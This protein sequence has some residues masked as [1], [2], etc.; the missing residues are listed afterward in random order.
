VVKTERAFYVAPDNGVLSMTLAQDPA[1]L[2]I[3]LMEPRYQL[4]FVST[5]FHGRDIFA[6]A[7]A[8]VACGTAPHQMGPKIP[9][10]DLVAFPTRPPTLQPDGSWQGEILHVDRF[11]NL[12]TNFRF[13][14]T[15][16]QSPIPTSE[17]C[18]VVGGKQITELSQTFADV[19]QGALVTYIG[20]DGYLEIAVR[21]R[22]AATEL[23][24]DVR[25]PV[26][27]RGISWS[28]A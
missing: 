12:V 4:P 27:V 1:Q 13:P 25:T 21:E 19:E 5:T 20:S 17:F 16:D 28:P 26:Q 8:Y 9:T 22:N 18:V 23:S 3:H 11:G 24:V 15:Q 10:S 14:M 7:G 6:P 2:A